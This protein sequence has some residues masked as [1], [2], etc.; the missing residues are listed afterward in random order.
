ADLKNDVFLIGAA[1]DAQRDLVAFVAFANHAQE[2]LEAVNGFLVDGADDVIVLEA[3]LLGGAV[4]EDSRQ[5][6]AAFDVFAERAEGRNADKAAALLAA[7]A[8]AAAL[9]AALAAAHGNDRVGRLVAAGDAEGHL[10]GRPR[11]AERRGDR[12]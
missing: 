3:S 4:I 1:Q 2:R 10:L 12:P 6:G 11:L 9:A 7:S 8:E 5:L